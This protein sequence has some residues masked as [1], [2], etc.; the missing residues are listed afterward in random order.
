MNVKEKRKFLPTHFP[1]NPPYGYYKVSLL[2]DL[3]AILVGTSL[4]LLLNED[5]Y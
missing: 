3:P 1:K 2:K 5:L 4:L